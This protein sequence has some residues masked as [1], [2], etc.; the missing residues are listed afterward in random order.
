[1]PRSRRARTAQQRPPPRERQAA[2]AR[3]SPPRSRRAGT[4]ARRSPHD[5]TSWHFPNWTKLL[6]S[7]RNRGRA[8]RARDRLVGRPLGAVLSELPAA[9]DADLHRHVCGR[10]GASGSGGARLEPTRGFSAASKAASIAN[11]KAFKKRIEKIKATLDRRARG[12]R[13]PE[14]PLRPRLCRRQP[15]RGRGLRRR[16]ADLAAD[17]ARR[18]RDLFDDYEWN[19]MPKRLDNPGPASMPFS[20]RSPANIASFTRAIRSRSRSC[21]RAGGVSSARKAH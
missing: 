19:E 10:P 6:N 1:M 14:P 16:R 9:R 7:R 21:E 15:S 4:T 17:G 20:S 11:T 3:R 18:P 13:H 12:A 5:W 8:A 2:G